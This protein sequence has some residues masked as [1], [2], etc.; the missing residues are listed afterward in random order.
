ML[1]AG[2]ETAISTVERPQTRTLDRAGC[3]NCWPKVR[4][5]MRLFLP[6]DDNWCIYPIVTVVWSL[7]LKVAGCDGLRRFTPFLYLVMP[8]G[9]RKYVATWL[10]CWPCKVGDSAIIFVTLCQNLT[11][12]PVDQCDPFPHFKISLLAFVW[13]AE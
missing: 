1:P 3:G 13:P 12:C 7:F 5:T 2:L 6:S 8:L 11:N 9:H 4:R 10:Y